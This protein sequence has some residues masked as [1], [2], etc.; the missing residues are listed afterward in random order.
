MFFRFGERVI[1]V[2]E[3]ARYKNMG[4]DIV[5]SKRS[6]CLF[7]YL[8]LVFLWMPT[9]VRAQTDVFEGMSEYLMFSEYEAGI[10][11]PQQLTEDIFQSA[12]FVDTRDEQ[13]FMDDH[14]PGAVHIE[15]RD[16]L[17]NIDDIPDTQLTILYCN[18]GT[19]S[20]QATFALRVLGRSNVVVLQSGF[21]GW[22]KQ[23][24]YKPKS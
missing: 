12:I 19:L 6:C 18:T 23:A 14:I 21:M 3:N 7:M 15:W 24:P 16:I 5:M 10:I 4:E 22:Q 9:H 17:E 2:S 8:M 13:Q 1:K 20:A 11:T